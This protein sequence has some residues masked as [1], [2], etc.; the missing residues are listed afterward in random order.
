MNEQRKNPLSDTVLCEECGTEV[1]RVVA[2]RHRET[3][4]KLSC[5]G[6]WNNFRNKDKQQKRS[7]AYKKSKQTLHI[8]KSSEKIKQSTSL[9]GKPA[10]MWQENLQ[11]D[12]KG[13][14]VQTIHNVYLILLNDVEVSGCAAYDIFT[15][16]ERLVNPT[17]WESKIFPRP[18]SK[19][20]D[21]GLRYYL[22]KNYGL[23]KK[24][25]IT[26]ALDLTF[27]ENS[28]HPVCDY[29]DSLKWDGVHRLDTM[30]IYYMGADDTPY[31]RAVTRKFLIAGAARVRN[32]GCKF[33]YMLIL[34]GSQGL[35]K[36]QFFTR[37][38][39]KAEYF[40]DS[41]SAFDNSKES[42]E[43]LAGKWIIEVG[44]LSV[45]KRSDVEHI[46]C[47]LS[48][49]EDAYRPSYGPRLETF[50]RQCIFAGTSNRDDFLRDATGGRRF[51]PVVVKDASRMWKELTPDIVDQVWAEA[52]QAYKA[53]EDLF[54]NNDVETQ[55][56][57]MQGKFTELGGKAG[58]AAEFLDRLLPS[59]WDT[60]SISEK[61]TWLYEKRDDGKVARDYVSGVEL[62]VEC[63]GG[64][65]VD[66]T[67]AK[68][69][70]MSDIMLQIPGW[71]R[72]DKSRRI[73]EYGKQR[74]F[75]RECKERYVGDVNVY[76]WEQ[77][78]I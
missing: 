77:V 72:G 5:F 70:E 17:P 32:P 55:A 14:L 22:E 3:T 4:G 10:E 49:Q 18:W 48:K 8:M 20:D 59:D 45:M 61:L 76:P 62:Y 44:E 30:L 38:A 36:S 46:K 66:Y 51:W 12:E 13:L 47:F 75:E 26:D 15:R 60:R 27:Q 24:E 65:V 40:S 50:P 19:V 34:V 35:G 2:E 21:A 41:V 68:A 69:Y 39:R 74:V 29:L 16:R 64:K 63:F 67:A 28:F 11:R 56:N 37:L 23:R 58:I 78:K 54:L 43:A 7:A 25:A 31:V 71:K 52:D 53:G 33:D 57:E 73:K 1:K 9:P 42:M 6:C